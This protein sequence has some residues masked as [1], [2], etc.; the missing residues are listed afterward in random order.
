MVPIC[1][2]VTFIHVSWLPV[3]TCD[4]NGAAGW[5]NRTW[6]HGVQA[7]EGAWGTGGQGG[8]GY[9]GA[10]LRRR[11]LHTRL[12]VTGEHLRRQ[13]RRRLDKQDMATRGTCRGGM[14]YDGAD[15]TAEWGTDSRGA[16]ITGSHGGK[17][18]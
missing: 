1:A 13:A 3:N 7:A 16:W 17:G 12:L 4:D 18:Y 5:T 8:L 2:G 14:G 11:H 6:R 10:D 15:L 9:D